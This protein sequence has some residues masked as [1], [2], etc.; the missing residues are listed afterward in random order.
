MVV[1]YIL[2]FEQMEELNLCEVSFLSE[3]AWQRILKDLAEGEVPKSECFQMSTEEASS[4]RPG[5]FR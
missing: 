5:T 1:D 2:I 3:Y 4:A